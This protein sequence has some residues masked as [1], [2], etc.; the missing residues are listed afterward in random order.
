[1][2]KKFFPPRGT[3][4]FLPGEMEIRRLIIRALEDIFTVYGYQQWDGPAFEHIETLTRKSGAAIKEEIYAFQDKKGRELGLR[5]DQTTS[6]ARM[7]A[8]NPHLKK[9]VRGYSAGKVWRYENTQKG[10]YREFMQMD[11]D[12][13]GSEHPFCEGELLHLAVNALHK[14]GFS[15]YRIRLNDRRILDAVAALAGINH[16]H[17]SD[18]FRAL[19]KLHKIGPAGVKKEMMN[20]GLAEDDY[21]RLSAYL[22]T[23]DN[24]RE[25]LKKMENAVKDNLAG[26]AGT[27]SLTAIL[28]QADEQTAALLKIDFTLVR[29][30]GYYTGPVYEIELAGAEGMGSI[31]AG[32]RYDELAELFGGAPTP[33]A[34]ISFGIER[35]FDIV[36]SDPGMSSKIK[37]EPVSVFVAYMHQDFA[38]HAFQLVSRI[39]AAGIPADFDVTGRSFRKQLRYGGERGCPYTLIVGEKEVSSGSYGLKNMAT[40]EQ[41][42]LGLTEVI[43]FLQ[44][45]MQESLQKSMQER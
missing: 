40:G 37:Q 2:E 20:Y 21:N 35:I 33:A 38:R 44:E 10:R 41:K 6:L 8:A 5:F 24:N 43:Q 17:K 36:A 7:V 18:A 29:G 9:P 28:N 23:G 4:D 19:D 34:G 12:I 14:L 16:D 32:G 13:I 15:D 22:F 45:S 3:R 26:R 30:L 31:A 1:M 42:N 39:R 25:L 27:D 11:V